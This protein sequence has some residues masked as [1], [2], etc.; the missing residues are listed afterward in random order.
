MPLQIVLR[1]AWN[2]IL[3]NKLRAG[4]TALGVM[5]GVA[6][7]IATLALGKGAQAAV[8]ASFR[9]LGSNQIQINKK[10]SFGQD[11]TNT[12]NYKNLTYE[13]GLQLPAAVPL[14]SDVEMTVQTSA[15]V[16]YGRNSEDGI[17]IIGSTA[18][19]LNRLVS[20][21]SVQPLNW[22]GGRQ[23]TA[24]D[25]IGEGRFFTPAEVLANSPVCV[26]GYQTA[27][28]LFEGDDPIGQSIWIGRRTFQV[29]GVL[30]QL[31]PTDPTSISG[32]QANMLID[33]PI[34]TAINDLFTQDTSVAIIANV[35]NESEIGQAEQEITS[36]LRKRHNIVP[37]SQGVYNDDFTLTTQ[38]DILGAQQAAA[39]TFAL[40]L[41]AMAAI[42]LIVG[43]IGIMNVMLISV[44]ERTREIGIRLA[45]GAR[46][47]DIIA[48]FLLEAVILSAA[49]GLLGIVI[50]ILA[51][52]L[53]ASLN[54]GQALLA[55]ESIPLSFAVA[56]LTGIAFGIYPAIRASQLD[57]IEALGYE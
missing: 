28:D 14:V 52:P 7:V 15:T 4:L 18:N 16:R 41:A 37:D 27:Q 17:N 56:L 32:S 13:D 49:S 54:N 11:N 5:I 34:G 53:A 57:P 47:R 23:L 20:S 8:Q 2:S 42:S 35:K 39:N 55:P 22:P 43:G 40:L 46:Q 45:V 10:M 12:S 9:S 50:G 44:S 48:Q 26:I 36:Y 38:N 24:Q 21:G 25:F 33:M 6:S 51:I 19:A 31:E 30:A 29:I 3:A 1:T